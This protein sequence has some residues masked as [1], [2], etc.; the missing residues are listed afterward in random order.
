MPASA[1]QTAH[2]QFELASTSG[3]SSASRC[4][5]RDEHQG[6]LRRASDASRALV[7]L[8]L[9]ADWAAQAQRGSVATREWGAQMLSFSRP[10]VGGQ[11]LQC[12]SCFARATHHDRF[13]SGHARASN[14]LVVQQPSRWTLLMLVQGHG[15]CDHNEWERKWNMVTSLPYMAVGAYQLR[16]VPALAGTSV[17]LPGLWPS[18]QML[19][20]SV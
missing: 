11:R 8:A 12:L 18:G 10:Q 14:S 15:V 16:S 6:T 17:R 19:S 20:G 3:T 13:C 4:E 5:D 9:Q 2:L 7:D 1:L